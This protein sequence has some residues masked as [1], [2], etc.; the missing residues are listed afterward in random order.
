ML[1]PAD[2]AGCGGGQ[3]EWWKI[4]KVE[5][6]T[7]DPPS[8]HFPSTHTPQAPPPNR[9]DVL[10]GAIPTDDAAAA[11]AAAQQQAAAD[12]I[13]AALQAVADGGAD[14]LKAADVVTDVPPMQQAVAAP[15]GGNVKPAA[16]AAPLPPATPKVAAPPP[17]PTATPKPAAPAPAPAPQPTPSATKRVMVGPAVPADWRDKDAL[18]TVTTTLTFDAPRIG[19]FNGGTRDAVRKA[20]EAT[21]GSEGELRS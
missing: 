12:D 16:G 17:P 13:S 20:V 1:C 11:A 19:P 6:R 2:A 15:V 5:A 21:V 7:W 8:S 14:L 9:R 18:A 3:G 4:K 10:R